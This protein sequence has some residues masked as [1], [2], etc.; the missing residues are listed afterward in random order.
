LYFFSKNLKISISSDFGF[1]KRIGS[2]KK[3]WTFCGTPEYVAPEVILNKGHDIAADYWSL[4]I[5]IF[6]LLC[7]NP[8]FVGNDPMNTYNIILKG[9]EAVDFPRRI[10]KVCASLV[11]RLCRDNAIERIGYNRGGIKEVQKHRW[12]DGFNWENLRNGTLE[13]PYIPQ[14]KDNTDLKNFEKYDEDNDIPL[15]DV[16]GWDQ[17]F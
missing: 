12:F 16:S 2:G 13:A 14:L 10:P 11:K 8:P 7:G 15:D 5:L 1:A 4:G 3:T 9:I 6:E 17:A